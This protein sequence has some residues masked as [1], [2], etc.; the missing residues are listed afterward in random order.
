[1]K[2]IEEWCGRRHPIAKGF[3]IVL[4]IIPFL[5]SFGL[6][7]LAFLYLSAELLDLGILP[8]MI[9]GYVVLFIVVSIHKK[10]S[11]K[12]LEGLTALLVF[13]FLLWGFC[14]LMVI[15][16]LYQYWQISL[17][18]LTS[19]GATF[20]VW[21]LWGRIDRSIDSIKFNIPIE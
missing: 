1:M 3:L 2:K 13:P 21:K 16:I 8:F 17:L 9:T 11:K 12:Y 20:V 10:L 19:V 15:P 7:G 6:V 5:V 14:H 18:L 4:P